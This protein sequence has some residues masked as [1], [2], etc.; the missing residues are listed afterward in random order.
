MRIQ[1]G[2]FR[3][4]GYGGS[5][6]YCHSYKELDKDFKEIEVSEQWIR[7]QR[8]NAF[9]ADDH[10]VEG[11]FIQYVKRMPDRTYWLICIRLFEPA[12]LLFKI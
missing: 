5:W 6:D 7:N 2:K 12:G 8:S 10:R 1:F 4:P 9:H 11:E 3:I